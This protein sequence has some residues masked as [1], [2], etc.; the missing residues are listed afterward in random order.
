MVMR[1]K[2]Q[3]TFRPHETVSEPFSKS[4][5]IAAGKIS[6]QTGNTLLVIRIVFPLFEV[7]PA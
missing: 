7:T 2:L 4:C 3:D 5:L 1:K 6:G